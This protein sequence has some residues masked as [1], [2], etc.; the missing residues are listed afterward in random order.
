MDHRTL[1]HTDLTVSRLCFGTMTFGKPVDQPTADRMVS[2]CLEE[3]I[4]F[5]DTANAYQLGGSETILGRALGEKRKQVV[6][7]TKVQHKMGD[8]PDQSGLSRAAILRQAEES[9]RRLGTDWID[10]YYLH[11]PDPA[12][13]IEESLEA[14]NTLVRDGKVRFVATSN[15]AAW[16]VAEM[17]WISQT[18]GWRPPAVSQPMYSL[19]AR[20]LEQEYL[21]MAERLGVSSFVYNPLAGGLLT[22]K[23]DV[24]AVTP[25]GRFDP[26]FWGKS[27]YA[28]R[29]WHPRTFEAVER[30]KTIAAQAGRSLISL[31]LNWVLHHTPADGLVL[32]ASRPEQLDQNLAACREGPLSPET[33]AA[34]DA[35]WD[36]FR[37]PVPTYNR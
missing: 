12:V 28:D 5:F 17:F 32:G 27:L 2:R 31:A 18:N 29:Y 23:H 24:H 19:V 13:P 7:A 8:G 9:L 10:L 4:D 36:E 1:P 6:L 11:Q 21:P 15:Y 20:G 34:C 33:V 14:M 30:L 37:G 3:G 16:Q 22:G 35:V 26:A 25:G